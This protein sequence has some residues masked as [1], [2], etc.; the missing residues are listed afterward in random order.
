M[1]KNIESADVLPLKALIGNFIQNRLQDKL[2]K[3]KDQ[4]EIEKIKQAYEIENWLTDAARRVSQIQLVTH[5]IKY[6]NPEARGTSIYLEP[7]QKIEKKSIVSTHTLINR[8]DDVVGNA[9]A[10]DVFK[11]LQLKHDNETILSRLLRNDEALKA[12]FPGTDEQKNAWLTA[13]ANIT[14]AKGAPTTHKLAK[15]I[16]FP[17]REKQY[18][19]IAPL[20]PTS[21]VQTVFEQIQTRFDEST[22]NARKARRENK[23][24][25]QGYREYVNLAVQ[26]FGGSKPQ[27]ISQLNSERGGKCYLLP[28]LPPVWQSQSMKPP[29]KIKSIFSK[30]DYRI[31]SIIKNL[32]KLLISTPHN[33]MR[34]RLVREHYIAEICDQ[35]LFFVAQ[36]QNLPPCWSADPNCKL[37][38]AQVF[39]L[40]PKRAQQDAE[41]CQQRQSVNWQMEVSHDF[42]AWLNKKLRI[43]KWL[44]L[45]DPEYKA[46]KK[47]LRHELSLLRENI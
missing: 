31:Q 25:P 9:A 22:K 8:K 24:H 18:H 19:I 38:A 39:W 27:N 43:K 5:A 7:E 20:F 11:F 33:N 30:F 16:Y 26:K 35:L 32:Q 44:N 10:L 6:Q 29:L 28:S 36:I 13:F 47:E 1:Q 12:A 37:S 42:A 40:D 2:D 15:Q 45:G 21:L 46:W 41:W 4:E 3:V 34:I 17:V 14:Q 23:S